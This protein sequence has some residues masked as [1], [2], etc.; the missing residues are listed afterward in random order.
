[1]YLQFINDSNKYP[2]YEENIKYIG[3]NKIFFY[4]SNIPIN[5]NGFNIYLE[6]EDETVIPYEDYKVI[7]NVKD[8]YIAFTSDTRDHY[9]YYIYDNEN[10]IISF[11]TTPNE[12]I[13][14]PNSIL[15]K[16]G[17]GA[18]YENIE[19]SEFLDEEGLPK[20]KVENNE[21]VSITDEDYLYLKE[22]RLNRAKERKIKFLSQICENNII[23]GID[24]NNK[25]YSYELTDQ[26]NLYNAVQLSLST[27]L[28]VPYHAD[29]YVC[30]LYPQEDIVAIYIAQQTNL[31]HSST[32]YNQLKSL[33]QSLTTVDEVN[34]VYYG[35][36]LTDEYL[37]KYNE[38][39][40][41]AQAIQNTFLSQG[42]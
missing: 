41:Q 37:E 31:T 13:Q 24:Y 6:D 32:Y 17:Q 28:S 30:E 22:R 15:L 8:N 1:M 35:Q 12:N 5:N 27:G 20:L 4:N 33:V 18:E 39:M 16:F 29:G 23:S 38:I 2:I 26:N 40:L 36:E 42:Q 21:I 11:L 7:Y 9:L 25:H 19:L 14:K 34:A 3:I 10:F